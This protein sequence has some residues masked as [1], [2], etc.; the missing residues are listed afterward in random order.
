MQP[1]N[2]KYFIQINQTNNQT[3]NIIRKKNIFK[4]FYNSECQLHTLTW[5]CFK[6]KRTVMKYK[7][8]FYYRCFQISFIYC[9]TREVMLQRMQIFNVGEKKINSK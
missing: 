1:L 4:S 5:I 6:N 2:L 3:G 9:R 8:A 7:P